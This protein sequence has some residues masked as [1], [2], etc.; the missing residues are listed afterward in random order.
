M[1]HELRQQLRDLRP[2]DDF[3]VIG[4]EFIGDDPRVGQL[5]VKRVLAFE[6][7]RVGFDGAIARTRHGRDDG[8]RIDSAAEKRAERNVADH[9]RAHRLQQLRA[10]ALDPFGLRAIVGLVEANVPIF[11]VANLPLLDDEHV[12]GKEFFDSFENR[13]GRGHVTEGEIFFQ[14]AHVH[15]ARHVLIF[16]DGFQLRSEDKPVRLAADVHRLFAEA[17]ARDDQALARHV[18][19]RHAEHPAQIF[20]KI[21]AFLFVEMDNRFGIGF[22]AEVVAGFFEPLAQLLEIINFAVQ[23]YPDRAVFIRH[24][25]VAAGNV[26]DAE[27]P[28]AERHAAAVI[29]AIVIGAAMRDDAAHP[30]HQRSRQLAARLEIYESEYS[31]HGLL[32]GHRRRFRRASRLLIQYLR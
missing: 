12:A 15:A 18:P 4:A 23:N 19:D 5:V 32:G 30:L 24:R 31:A 17:V 28:H 16:E 20:H 3:V 26:D 14:R 22:R 10:H 1:P 11:L 9:L 29:K 27:A 25:L 8:A 13:G 6:S 21:C 2:H 7:D